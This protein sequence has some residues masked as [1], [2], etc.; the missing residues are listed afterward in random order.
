[1]QSPSGGRN[2]S[3]DS[4]TLKHVSLERSLRPRAISGSK[5]VVRRAGSV[6]TVDPG[7]DIFLHACA[8]EHQSGCLGTDSLWMQT[9]GDMVVPTPPL[10]SEKERTHSSTPRMLG[11]HVGS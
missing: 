2:V 4:S 6:P 8:Q 9:C 7:S 1:M 11:H 10:G 3:C 5:P